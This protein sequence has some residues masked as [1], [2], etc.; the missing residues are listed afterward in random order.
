MNIYN[1]FCSNFY[2]SRNCSENTVDICG[3]EK[4]DFEIDTKISDL[5]SIISIKASFL[6]ILYKFFIKIEEHLISHFTKIYN[7]AM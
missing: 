4:I 2:S 1:Y 7:A 6:Y 3:I 5:F